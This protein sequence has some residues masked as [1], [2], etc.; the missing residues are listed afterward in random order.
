MG[1]TET[2]DLGTTEEIYQKEQT[3][4]TEQEIRE[5]A[6]KANRRKRKEIVRGKEVER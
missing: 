3:D 4:Q 2:Q 5:Q 1:H 6:R